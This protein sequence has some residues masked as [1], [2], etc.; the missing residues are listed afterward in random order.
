MSA[1]YVEFMTPLAYQNSRETCFFG[2]A[3]VKWILVLG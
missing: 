3:S 2:D 1:Q